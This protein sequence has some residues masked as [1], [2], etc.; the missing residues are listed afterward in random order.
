M[1]AL[2]KPKNQKKPHKEHYEYTRDGRLIIDISTV[3]GRNMRDEITA[4]AWSRD[5]GIC[6]ICKRYVCLLDAVRDHIIPC[7]MG[8][9]TRDDSLRNIQ[10]AHPEC[11]NIKGSR[12]DFFI[13]P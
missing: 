11:N 12:R 7:G 1:G 13:A 8:G 5:D 9:S 2:L 10:P 3:A 6:G 4:K